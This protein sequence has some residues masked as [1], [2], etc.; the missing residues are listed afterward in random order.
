MTPSSTRINYYKTNNDFKPYHHDAA[1]FNP[2][3]AKYQNITVGVSFGCT[4][5]ISFESC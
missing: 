5:E 1:A 2:E 3:K 4:R